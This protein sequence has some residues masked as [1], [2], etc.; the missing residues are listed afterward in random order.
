[1]AQ[2]KLDDALNAIADGTPV[3][4]HEIDRSSSV[5]ER[6]F[7]SVQLLHE[8]A[9]AFR[10]SEP[11]AS[12][13]RPAPLFRWGTLEVEQRLGAG[14]S[15]EVWRAF[16]P[17]LGRTVALKLQRIDA[18]A[19]T[20]R[21]EQLDEA[22][23]LAQIRHPNVLS[24][25][26]CAVHDGRAGL[27]SELIEGR[28]LAEVLV[29]DGAFSVEETLRI[30]RDL[31]RALA[32]VHAA[33]LV[34]GDLKAANVMRERGG[35]IVLM[36]FGAGGEERLLASRRLVSATPAYLAPEVLDGAPLSARSD[37]YALGVLLFLMLSGRMPYAEDS[38]TGL[39]A[40]QREGRRAK[41]AALR[42]D[43]DAQVAATIE[44][45]IEHDPALR[46]QDASEI[47]AALGAALREVPAPAID[48][49]VRARRWGYAVGG[50]AAAAL[51][52]AIGWSRLFA[53]AWSAD[54]AFI[55]VRGDTI[56]PLAEHATVRVGDRLRLRLHSNR[57]SY[58]YVLNEDADGNATVLYPLDRAATAALPERTETL[59]PGDAQ[60]P[61]L[62]WQVTDDSA[63]EEFLVVAALAPIAS[64]ETSIADWRRSAQAAHDQET[65]RS[66]GTVVSGGDAPVLRG[67]HLR[68]VLTRLPRDRESVRTWR[69]AFTHAASP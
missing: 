46:P 19:L 11:A 3:P 45:C 64:L 15:G 55:R 69:F 26:G 8:V 48:R 51:A 67:V 58:V 40:A 59:L 44:R 27:W 35:R 65:T 52:L 56:E 63:R 39:R 54:A 4:W 43:L 66:L 24:C 12:V 13:P 36:D 22:R 32:V 1:M 57:A 34:H 20:R 9:R 30:G 47:V 62:A 2:D 49:R 14:S 28:S 42:T 17:W 53:P 25:Y 18:N 21:S 7:D 10:A 31:A 61:T 38:V 60:D 68:T 37:L 16:D 41:L 29:E 6:E 5:P 23:R 50:A 33:G